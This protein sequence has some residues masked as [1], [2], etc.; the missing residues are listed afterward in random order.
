[1]SAVT[2][3][4]RAGYEQYGRQMIE[5]VDRHWPKDVILYCYTEGFTPNVT[6]GRVVLVDL[7]SA[8]PELVAFKERHRDNRR[9]HGDESHGTRLRVYV[10]P[11]TVSRWSIPKVKV[12]RMERGL[13]YRWNA[14]RF[15]H[16]SFAIFDASTRCRSDIL[17]W[18]DADTLVFDTIP[19]AFLEELIPP[20][21][22]LAF[23]KRPKFSE[24]GFIAYNL[25]HPAVRDFFAEFKALYTTDRLFS[26]QEYHDSW[27]FDIVRKRF[28]RRKCKTFDIAEGQGAY[29][30]HVFINSALG[31]YMDHMKGG[32][33]VAG[34]SSIRDLIAPRQ[35]PYWA[36]LA[37]P[38]N[39]KP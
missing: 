27:L 7:L 8:C 17:F 25:R 36:R 33:W 18:V 1:M 39:D 30:G 37:L 26:E 12:V 23:L 32:R 29:A 16:K 4:N 21:C 31:R 5:S 24:C 14:V 2:T 38:A 22:L 3:F 6:G 35:E 28:E 9:A 10:R 13:G 34:S 15:S 19:R 20:D 11:R